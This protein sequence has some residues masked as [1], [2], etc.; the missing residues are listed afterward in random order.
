MLV[1]HKKLNMETFLGHFYLWCFFCEELPLPIPWVEQIVPFVLAQWNV[2]KGGVDTITK[3]LWLNMYDPPSNTP[4]SHAIA[5]LI[6]LGCVVMHRLNHF[7]TSKN[8]IKKGYPYLS[9]FR[10]AAS[11]RCTF[12]AMPLQIVQAMMLSTLMPVVVSPG[13][14]LSKITGVHTWTKDTRTIEVAWGA[15]ST[16]AIPQWSVEKKYSKIDPPKPTE[17]QVLQ[18][19]AKCNGVPVYRVN[20]VTKSNKGFGS[21][22]RCVECRLTNIFCFICKK[23]LCDPQLPANYSDDTS[24]D[25]SSFKTPLMMGMSPE[26]KKPSVP[27]ILVGKN[28]TKL[29]FNQAGLWLKDRKTP[30]MKLMMIMTPCVAMSN[31]L[32]CNALVVSVSK[33]SIV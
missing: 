30:L 12:H 13:S 32:Q 27:S 26:K 5:R 11:E 15:T 7:F 4:E 22:S 24:S 16:G 1:H 33:V 3:L 19:M 21:Q 8:Y 31:S 18:C 6:L 25:Q 29:H 14:L 23:W 17:V 2:I 28:P 20:M 9:H 10:K